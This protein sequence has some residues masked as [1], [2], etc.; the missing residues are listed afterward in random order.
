MTL[1]TIDESIVSRVTTLIDDVWQQAGNICRCYYY[2]PTL[3]L[4]VEKSAARKMDSSEVDRLQQQHQRLHRRQRRRRRQRGRRRC[5][6][7]RPLPPLRHQ[8]PCMQQRG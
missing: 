8:D 1:A 5:R 7:R 3:L 2:T 4:V 6:D